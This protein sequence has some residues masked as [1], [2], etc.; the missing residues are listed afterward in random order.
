MLRPKG[1]VQPVPSDT[2]KPTVT[3]QPG[4][5]TVMPFQ[6]PVP[7]PASEPL[8]GGVSRRINTVEDAEK[9][10]EWMIDTYTLDVKLDAFTLDKTQLDVIGSRFDSISTWWYTNTSLK[11]ELDPGVG[12]ARAILNG[13]ENLLPP[14]H[15]QIAQRAKQIVSSLITPGMSDLEKEIAIHDYIIYHCDYEIND[16]LHTGDARGFFNHGRV[17]CAGY[18]DVFQ[19]LGM[20]SGLE[21]R[22]VSGDIVGETGGHEWNLILLDGLWYG[23]DCT[24]DDPVGG[25]NENHLYL[26]FPHHQLD[27]DHIYDRAMLPDGAYCQNFDGN[28]YPIYKGVAV[29]NTAEAEQQLRSQLASSKTAMFYFLGG[30][31]D[32]Q[33]VVRK[34]FPNA[35][36]TYW[37]SDSS[38]RAYEYKVEMN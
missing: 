11:L 23:V 33:A 20:L 6:T 19:L 38:I 3:A 24:W 18:S 14:E 27:G 7:T 16:S 5:A 29:S 1:N 2:R 12:A 15:A 4:K 26:N 35:G 36:Y 22:A 31:I 17:Q 13:K 9:L 28:Y 30:K 25:G 8:P 37:E 32:I 21:I 34:C 10:I